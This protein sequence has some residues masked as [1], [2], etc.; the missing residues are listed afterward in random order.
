M[1]LYDK[2]DLNAKIDFTDQSAEDWTIQKITLDAAYD[3]D[4]L[5]AYLFLP[6]NASAPYQT[7]VFFPGS[8]AHIDQNLTNNQ[9]TNWFLDFMLKSGRAVMYP[10]YIGTFERNVDIQTN[11]SEYLRKCI[12]DLSRSIDYLTTR[13]DIDTSKLGYYGHSWGGRLGGIIPAVED[14]IKISILLLGGLSGNKARPLTDNFNYVT[15]IKIPVLMLNGKFDFS[16]DFQKSV[17]PFY[18]HLGTSD[19]HKRL[20]VYDT[21]HYIP[22][23]EMIKESLD[24][25]DKYF[26]QV[27]MK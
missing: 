12:L 8:G 7:L 26:G 21:D 6:K 23:E 3:K 4:K 5:I 15:R 1:F 25:L 16:F 2:T 17:L 11:P 22:K 14:R 10:V 20:V 18:K 27:K 13:S 19:Q 9:Q 24:W